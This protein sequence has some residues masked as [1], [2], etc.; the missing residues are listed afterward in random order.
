MFLQ[1]IRK[2]LGRAYAAPLAKPYRLLLRRSR[3]YVLHRHRRHHRR[4]RV[5]GSVGAFIVVAI[6]IIVQV[7]NAFAFSTWTQ[8]DWSGGI[9]PSTTNQYAAGTNVDTTTANQ[10]TLSKSTA[11]WYNPSW[12]YRQSITF[13]NTT[14]NLGT[15]SEALT[16][17]PV[18]IKLTSANFD[19]SQAQAQGQDIRFTASDGTTPL[20]YEI[21]SWDSTKQTAIIWVNVPT[22][23]AESS[24]DRIYLY[25]DNAAATDGQN[26]TGTW[27]SAY[28]AVWH[29]DEASGQTVA[30]STSH[31]ADGAA[32]GAT[33]TT[34]AVFGMARTFPGNTNYVTTPISNGVT[35]TVSDWATMT[36]QGGMMWN[37]LSGKGPDLW[38]VNGHFYLNTWD[39]YSNPICAIPASASDGQFHLYE[40]VI[41]SS[42]TALY[43]DGSLCGTAAYR[44]PTGQFHISSG[45]GYDWHG[46][47]DEVRV[48]NV[49]RSAAWAAANYKSQ[50]N[51]FA[52]F[53]TSAGN[54]Q[55]TGTLTSNIYNSGIE[56][57]WANLIYTATV[58]SGTTLSVKVRT[59][60]QSDLS[61]A[62]AFSS[63][64]V[65]A[66]GS[67]IAGVCA[68]DKTQYVQYQLSFTATNGVTT[69]TLSNITA[70]FTPSDIT[71]P[72]TNATNPKL[73]KNNGGTRIASDGW[74][75]TYPYAT[76]VAGADN[77]GG[78]GIK[79]YCLYLGQDPT[80]D[81]VT[82]KGF[83]GTSP[84]NTNGAC[85]F[86]VSTD[87]VDLSA[88][89]YI[90]TPL[91]SS[92]SPY[93]LSIKAIDNADNVYVGS[94]AQI[95]FKFDNT[96]PENPAF[97]S[98]PSQFVSN[99]A[100]DLTWPT[101]GSD[102]A[103]DAISGVA[104][105]Q[106]KIGANGVWYGAS[107]SG[108]QDATDL[109]TN[110]GS[111]MTVSSP[112]FTSLKEGNNLVYFR[113]WDTAGNVS[114]AYITA[115]IKINTTSPSNP[116]N[117]T[118][119]PSTN[120]SNAFSFSW[121]PPATYSGSES[122]I[123]YCYTVNTL[124]NANNCT[125]TAPGQN[126]LD[127]GAYATQPGENTFYVVA[128]DEAGNINYAT[129]ATTTF[130]ANTAAPGVPLNLDIADIS[131]K[132]TSNWKLALSW[133]APSNVGAGVATYKIY[134]STNG[135]TYTNV[136]STA[137]TSYV[138]ASLNQQ[139]YY[140][141][142]VACDSA[143]NC[144]GYTNSVKLLPTGKFTSPANL[145]VGP[146]VTAGTRTAD[147][148]WTTD[149]TSDSSIAYGLSSGHY[150]ATQAA[151]SDQVVSHTITLNN[152]AAGTTYYYR[153]HWTDIDGNEGIS[154]EQ[155]FTTQPA[156][157]VSD[158]SIANIN[159]HSATIQ[160]TTSR[161]SLAKIYY[162]TSS[163]FGSV[164]TLNTSSATSGY[165][166]DL[167]NLNDGTKYYFKINTFD[168]S[169]NE[170]DTGQI[171][172]FSTP[173]QPRI[174]NVRFQPVPG[175][176]TGTEQITWTT[177]VPTTS[178]L[179]YGQ[180]GKA[181]I[182]AL[183]SKMVTEHS[184][185]VANLS[186]NTQYSVIASSR[187]ALGNVAN[188]DK[189]I[190]KSGLDTRPPTVSDVTAQPSIRGNGAS[191]SGQIVVS[192]KTDKPGSSQVAYGQ[193]SGGDYSSKTAEDTALVTNHVVVV[194]NL[195]TSQVFHLQAISR[196]EAGNVGVSQGQTAIISQ[197]SDSALS[198]IFNSLQAVFDYDRLPRISSKRRPLNY[199]W[200]NASIGLIRAARLDG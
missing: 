148:T 138:D 56:E 6:I 116:Q 41:S 177:N 145:L 65:I 88:T 52:T 1:A 113:T 141:K 68:P 139:T 12:L 76:W 71:P 153:A 198:I 110:G 24:T 43:Y 127:A 91:A 180:V 31:H 117:V 10:V 25:F 28:E 70:S 136:A 158:V 101:T 170:Y 132:A 55:T 5:F 63:C 72:T 97:V 172:T 166:V 13:N 81:P 125:F 57:N 75:N 178:G 119:S 37:Q 194:S 121:L 105:L 38:A 94:P 184:M 187:D 14:A 46:S 183:D 4:V 61:D 126:T 124:P 115:V 48:S 62:L 8:S 80:A 40:M 146:N 152:L 123:T 22:I 111:Y 112:D 44:N 191:A 128:K 103:S 58:P 173:P 84:M 26:K 159:L 47:I 18:L 171:N 154:S 164:E 163:G 199:S 131:T 66:S 167:S 11:S 104:G 98:A 95:Q 54:Y 151:N 30:D 42:L 69:P 193:G 185:E 16:D 135:T 34:T 50:T 186:Y 165:I 107:H 73:Y 23:T 93:Y 89:G 142:I 64:P 190:F 67:T 120:T 147:I 49:A 182:D 102:A 156:P 192:W 45:A 122:N 83:L 137:G 92:N 157:T 79:G 100:V 176:L 27:N 129:A 32:T 181:Q 169:N 118:A 87:S 33:P 3:V 143:N 168:S 21:E 36:S 108:T 60:N 109:L 149:R 188:S 15:T 99:K 160:F 82:T 90:G 114:P 39:S 161:A 17:F 197:A 162:G 130:T 86:A 144:G 19:F 179:L 150:L 189:Q 7:H 196:D 155:S 51:Q 35:V 53:G 134:R 78:S 175:A 2:L 200:R 20:N 106:Y 59:G 74:A 77:G 174:T 9:G 195:P 85:Q 96:P 133:E 140:Y 29:M